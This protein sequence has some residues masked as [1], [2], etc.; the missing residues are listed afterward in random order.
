MRPGLWVRPLCA[1]H[2]EKASLLLPKIP[3]RNDPKNPVLDPTIPENIERIKG[4]FDVYKQ[5][6]YEMV[7]HDYT[8]ND[9]SGRWGFEMKD[10]FTAPGWSFYD[11]TKTTAEVINHLYTSIREAAGEHIYVIGCNTMSHLSAG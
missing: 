9:I 6:G 7:K 2:D 10:S 3:G 8:T 4:Y 11:K 5:W 1:R